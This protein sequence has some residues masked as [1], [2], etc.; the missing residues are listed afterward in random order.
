MQHMVEWLPM[1][2]IFAPVEQ[3]HSLSELLVNCTYYDHPIAIVC[4][5]GICW[6]SEV[7]LANSLRTCQ[8]RILVLF[9]PHSQK[10]I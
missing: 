1:P 8:N 7:L 3:G 10:R 4:L 6:I 2:Q 5:P 9:L